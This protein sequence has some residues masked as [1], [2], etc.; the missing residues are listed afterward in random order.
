MHFGGIAPASIIEEEKELQN[1][2]Q[3]Q[4]LPPAL[5]LS[6]SYIE[7]MRRQAPYKKVEGFVYL[8]ESNSGD[9]GKYRTVLEG[10]DIYCYAYQSKLLFMYSLVWCF[11]KQT[12]ESE[13]INGTLY[14]C[15]VIKLNS[16][17]KR[18]LYFKSLLDRELWLT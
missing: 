16:K 1:M 12:E 9:P 17:F 4:P 3:N 7:G 8:K 18:T 6:T 14:Y 15:L 5:R 2:S 13:F 11:V 10:R